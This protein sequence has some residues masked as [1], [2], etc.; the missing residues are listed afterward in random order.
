[1]LLSIMIEAFYEKKIYHLLFCSISVTYKQESLTGPKTVLFD[2]NEW[3]KDGSLALAETLYTKD[4]TLVAY[5]VRKS[6]SDWVDIKF[7][8][9]S[10][11]QDIDIVLE[12]GREPIITWSN[13]NNAIFYT[14]CYFFIF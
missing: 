2:P 13:D 5:T 11:G 8:N 4:G 14:V 3:T 9:V 1:M 7:K 10:T 12:K 6:G